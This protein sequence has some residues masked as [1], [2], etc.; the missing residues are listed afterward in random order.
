MKCRPSIARAFNIPNFIHK[1]IVYIWLKLKT[2][3]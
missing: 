1:L 3:F 2:N